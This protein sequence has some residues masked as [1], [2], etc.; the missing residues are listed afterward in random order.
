MT[1]E[2]KEALS[3]L[4]LRKLKDRPVIAAVIVLSIIVAG[5]A[6]FSD[7][8]QKLAAVFRKDQKADA[9][10]QAF[11]VAESAYRQRRA[12]LIAALYDRKDACRTEERRC[13][14]PAIA[15]PA[16]RKLCPRRS[17]DKT[18]V[19]ALK[20]VLIIDR[21]HFVRL[22]SRA[23]RFVASG[24]CRSR[25]EI[26]DNGC[27]VRANDQTDLRNLDLEGVT[28]DYSDLRNVRLQGSNL[29]R[30]S[31]TLSQLDNSNL[32][33]CELTSA[34]FFRA[35]LQS[36]NL[37]FSKLNGANLREADLRGATIA[38]S[39]MLRAN[40]EGASTDQVVSWEGS[41][42]PDGRKMVANQSCYGHR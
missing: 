39:T 35:S 22:N 17:S 25:T 37:N 38:Y 15:C 6:S 21:T 3:D 10:E 4:W 5:V 14:P 16:E 8:V 34:E 12:E 19:E 27:S 41:T 18:A 32:A 30:V 13:P 42:C 40:F 20:E 23:E 24:K 9:D 11:Q 28:L 7:S 1:E 29:Q 26:G 36:I 33:E 2:R 31:F